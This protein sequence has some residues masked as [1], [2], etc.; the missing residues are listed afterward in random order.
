VSDTVSIKEYVDGR[1]ADLREAISDA[2][3]TMEKRL[4]GMNE[5]RDSLRDQSSKFATKEALESLD[6]QVQDLRI[7]GGGSEGRAAGLAQWYGWIVAAITLGLYALNTF[8]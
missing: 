8:R 2:R 7:T 5:F 3:G 1:F 4:E 6:R